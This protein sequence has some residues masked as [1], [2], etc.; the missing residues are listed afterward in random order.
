MQSLILRNATDGD[1]DSVVQILTSSREAYLPYAISP[2]ALDDI[3]KWVSNILVP[4]SEVVIAQQAGQ[5]VGVLAMSESNQT[6]WIEQLY[7]APGFTGQGI[8]PVLIAHALA[9]L[10]RPIHLW[11][12]QQN[13]KARRFYENQGF[14]VIKTTDGED[15][16]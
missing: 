10:P 3:H 12:F 9:Q 7:L 14:V 13:L 8:G 15:N 16:E 5:D 11:T 4:T 2:H 6:A 1:V